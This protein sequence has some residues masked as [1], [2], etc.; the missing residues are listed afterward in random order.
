MSRI[1]REQVFGEGRRLAARTAFP[2]TFARTF[3]QSPIGELNPN[4][5]P[6]RWVVHN[7]FLFDDAA[8][9]VEGWVESDSRAS[10]RQLA[11]V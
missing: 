3:T 9:L 6:V 7:L 8:R 4:G 11:A 10:I 5:K 2:G 1:E